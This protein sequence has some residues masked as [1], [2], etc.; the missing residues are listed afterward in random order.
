[1]NELIEVVIVNPASV[2]EYHPMHLHGYSFAV[3][4]SEIIDTTK[5][6][7][8][9]H[10]IER[11]RAGLLKRNLNRPIVKDTISV[12]NFGYTIIRFVTDNP[13]V[14]MFHCHLDT[15]SE[16]AMMMLFRVGKLEDLPSRPKDWPN[17]TCSSFMPQLNS[18]PLSS[19]F[20]TSINVRCLITKMLISY[21]LVS[22]LL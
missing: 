10:V 7:Q 11:D 17:P 14:W 6:I 16:V 22:L 3:I 4:G 5:P 9:A 13:G 1:M 18:G 8:K 12:P 15:H 2:V 21:I 20:V 19:S